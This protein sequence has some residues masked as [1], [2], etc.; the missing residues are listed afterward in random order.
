MNDIVSIFEKNEPFE[1]EGLEGLSVAVNAGVTAAVQKYF[2]ADE[3]ERTEMLKAW[4]K[5]ADAL[6]ETNPEVLKQFNQ[7]FS[8][9]EISIKNQGN[10][11]IGAAVGGVVGAVIGGAVGGGLPGA[12]LGARLG[13]AIGAAIGYHV[14]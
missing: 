7:A 9:G 3:Y 11:A 13:I 4:K 6:E 14:P 1:V 12:A 2:S 8:D 5:T 10:A